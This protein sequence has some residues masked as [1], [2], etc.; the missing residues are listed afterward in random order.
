[1]KIEKAQIESIDKIMELIKKCIEDMESKG[2]Y[3]WNMHYPTKDIFLEDINHGNLYI[4]IENNEIF[5]IITFDENQSSEYKD[6]SWISKNGKVLVIH[7]LAI[8]PIY[9]KHGF[10]RALMDFAEG[11]AYKKGFNSI[12]LDAYSGNQRTLKFYENRDYKK[13]GQLYFPYRELPFYCY[14]KILP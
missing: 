14:E 4:L 5:G 7:R 1:M 10:G 12:R 3:Q 13:T 8:N 9:Q 11:E 2:I 6:I